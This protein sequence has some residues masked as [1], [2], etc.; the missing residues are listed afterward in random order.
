MRK[1]R[2]AARLHAPVAV[3]LVLNLTLGLFILKRAPEYLRDYQL[4][5][6]SD[7][8]HYVRL[9]MNWWQYGKYSR[10]EGPPFVPDVHRTPVY[11]LL[12]GAAPAAAG[13]IWPLYLV[14]VLAQV[15]TLWALFA[16]VRLIWSDSVA[17]IAAAL[18]AIDFAPAVGNWQAMSE[19]VFV[20]VSTLTCYLWVRTTN[21]SAQGSRQSVWMYGFIGALSGLA[22][23]VR[24]TGLYLG[25]VLAVLTACCSLS[26]SWRARAAKG[27]IVALVA[28]AVLMPWVARNYARF[29]VARLTTIDVVTLTYYGA[30]S[31]Y[32]L[33]DGVS[34]DEGARR[35]AAEHRLPTKQQAHNYWIAGLN[36]SET[37]K[38]QKQAATAVIREHPLIFMRAAL[39][40]I[41]QASLSHNTP[42][43]AQIVRL[44]WQPPGFGHVLAGDVSGAIGR[45]AQNH[46]LLVVVFVSE[47][48]IAILV[49]GLAALSTIWMFWDPGMSRGSRSLGLALTAI[50]LYHASS[51]TPHGMDTDARFRAAIA[52][53]ACALAAYSLCRL[54]RMAYEVASR[55]RVPAAEMAS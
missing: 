2:F 12:A 46:P 31:V 49:T 15:V 6:N 39:Q 34:L 4:N 54:S 32:A 7:A 18:Y 36:V 47:T 51:I 16:L 8:H 41:A 23:L 9:G 33:R 14:Q 3:A 19:P 24:P 11:P 27:A 29:G 45:I 44:E 5:P 40:G 50:V 38:Q 48:L 53:L 28:G 21:Q 30:A 35:M 52:P 1:P 17:V 42:E 13:V 26:E 43:L 37:D 25:I 55:H 10:Q 22:A 20:A